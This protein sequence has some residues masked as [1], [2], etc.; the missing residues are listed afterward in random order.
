MI[1]SGSTCWILKARATGSSIMKK[2]F[3]YSFYHSVKN[4]ILV[5]FRIFYRKT[6]F[7]RRDRLRV[8]RPTILVTN[9]PSTMTDPLN[10]AARMNTMVHFLA[11]A[12]MFQHWFSNWFFSTFYCIPIGRSIDKTGKRKVDN[13]DSFARCDDFLTGGGCLYIAPEGGSHFERRLQ[14]LKTGTARIALSAENKND[15]Q[16][17]LVLRPVGLAY[18]AQTDFRSDVLVNSGAVL[19]VAD[20]EQSYR[21]DPIEAV[22]QLTAD[23]TERLRDLVIH[24]QDDEEDTTLRQVEA[25]QQASEPLDWESHVHRTR[26]TLKRLQQLRREKETYANWRERLTQLETALTERGSDYRSLHDAGQ[27][28]LRASNRRRALA[29][30]LGLPLFLYGW[31]NNYLANAI[32]GFLAQWSMPPR[33]YIGYQSTVK[34]MSALIFYPLFYGI[35]LYLVQRWGGQW[36]LTALY[37]LSLYPTGIFAWRYRARWRTWRRAV[38][39]LEWRGK[40]AETVDRWVA[41]QR[42]LLSDLA[43]I[44]AEA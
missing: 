4:L 2:L 36:W 26:E 43:Q 10:A 13:E 40:A 22:Q 27:G 14:R 21:E 34:L 23:L 3:L 16:L 20:Y 24:T 7:I 11:N 15:F 32:P 25:I 30:I 18:S 29:L 28:V 8:D 37:L 39:M 44:K 17:G 41:T 33:L 9:H 6:V 31:I 19:R 5:A 38:R 1:W 12:G 35:Q 42:D